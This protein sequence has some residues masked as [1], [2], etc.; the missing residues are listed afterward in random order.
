[1]GEECD[2]EKRISYQQ[3]F[4]GFASAGIK[5]FTIFAT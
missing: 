3:T 1:M 5:K 2:L 4:I